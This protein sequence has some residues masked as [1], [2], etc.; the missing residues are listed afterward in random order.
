MQTGKKNLVLVFKT[1]LS[2]H[3]QHAEEE[4]LNG[5]PEVLGQTQEILL[6]QRTFLLTDVFEF[7]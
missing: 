7:L 2:F 3:W 6:L 4:G 1:V 5:C